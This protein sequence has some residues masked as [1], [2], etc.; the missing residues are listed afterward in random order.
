MYR[1]HIVTT[2]FG[3][4]VVIWAEYH[5]GP[6]IVQV[7]L[8]NPM[9]PAEEKAAQLFP[10]TLV[11]SCAEIDKTATSLQGI[12]EGDDIE[13]PLNIV[14]LSLCSTF[15]QSVLHAEH[16]IPRGHVSSYRNI[17]EHIGKPKGARAVGAALAHNPFPL[18]V[19]CHRAIRSDRNLGGYQ[20]GLDMKRAL[21][22][23]EGHVFDN[24]GRIIRQR[25]FYQKVD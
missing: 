4:L 10:G 11:L 24:A 5:R 25:F 8:S 20:G 22:E 9:I 12:L 16:R 15:Q 2:S 3:P 7:I 1:K 23:K 6:I 19:P 17:A 21:L 18:I 13:F 14:D